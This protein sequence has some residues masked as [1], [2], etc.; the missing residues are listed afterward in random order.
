MDIL[1]VELGVHLNHTLVFLLM[2]IEVMC[3]QDSLL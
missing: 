1:E 3:I 2:Q